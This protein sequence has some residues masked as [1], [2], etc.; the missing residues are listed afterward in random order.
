MVASTGIEASES[1]IRN[2]NLNLFF[3]MHME[4]LL[5]MQTYTIQ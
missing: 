1:H 2:S 3:G 4:T 5:C